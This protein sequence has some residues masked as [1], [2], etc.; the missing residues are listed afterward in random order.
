MNNI[1]AQVTYFFSEED[2]DSNGKLSQLEEVS[3]SIVL[4]QDCDS[5]VWQ[6][7]SS[8]QYTSSSLYTIVNFRVVTQVCFPSVWKIIM[9]SRVHIFHWYD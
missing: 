3:K 8:G 9:P 7:E 1:Q 6:Y 2:N 5:L 4:S